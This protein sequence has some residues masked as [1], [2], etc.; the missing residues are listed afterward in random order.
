MRLSVKF[1][2]GPIE[3]YILIFFSFCVNFDVVSRHH[4]TIRFAIS[5]LRYGILSSGRGQDKGGVAA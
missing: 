2:S 5:V 4:A 1:T 3:E